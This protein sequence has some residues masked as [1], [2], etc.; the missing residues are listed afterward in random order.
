VSSREG[1]L[2]QL[3]NPFLA[4]HARD[5]FDSLALDTFVPIPRDQWRTLRMED[6]GDAVL[7]IGSPSEITYRDLSP[8]LC[9]DAAYMKMRLERFALVGLPQAAADRLKDSAPEL[10]RSSDYLLTRASGLLSIN[11]CK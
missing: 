7:D 6:Q 2:R 10:H 11:S 5:S 4:Q 1:A 3:V 8:T 9:D